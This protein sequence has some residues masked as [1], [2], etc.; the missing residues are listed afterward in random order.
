MKNDIIKDL[1]KIDQL[2]KEADELSN[3][4]EKIKLLESIVGITDKYSM[5][6]DSNHHTSGTSENIHILASKEVGILFKLRTIYE[7]EH[8]KAEKQGNFE[9]VASIKERIHEL[10]KKWDQALNKV[11]LPRKYD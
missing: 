3:N 5:D 1:E 7:K 9:N 8:T 4:D 10:D 2:E 6:L 11:K